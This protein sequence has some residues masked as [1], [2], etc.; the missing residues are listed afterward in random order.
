MSFITINWSVEFIV[1]HI[2]LEA[3]SFYKKKA[4]CLETEYPTFDQNELKKVG[5]YFV[6]INPI[7]S[8]W[9]TLPITVVNSQRKILSGGLLF[10]SNYYR[11]TFNAY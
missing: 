4:W 8:D 2:L 6:D 5:K 10:A 9:S 11:N 1:K 7:T 3:K